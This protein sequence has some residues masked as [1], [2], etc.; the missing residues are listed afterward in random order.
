MY[1]LLLLLPKPG[2]RT[3][4]VVVVVLA[5]GVDAVWVGGALGG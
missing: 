5:V 4:T 3:Q 2:N 1:G